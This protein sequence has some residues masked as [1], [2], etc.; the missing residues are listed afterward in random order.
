MANEPKER[1]SISLVTGKMQKKTIMT[2]HFTPTRM[3][4][5]KKKIGKNKCV[6]KLKLLDTAG[7]ASNGVAAWAKSL[8][9][10]QKVQQ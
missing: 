1:C 3:A 10:L 8:A 6:E 2:Y 7:G 5:M 4:K 9:V